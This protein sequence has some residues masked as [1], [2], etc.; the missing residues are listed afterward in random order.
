MN[1]DMNEPT[2]SASYASND[3]ITASSEDRFNRSRFATSLATTIARRH[4]SSCL[5]V[6][7]YAKWGE[8]KTSLLNLIAEALAGET[9]IVIV[10]FDPW[11]IRSEIEL[12]PALFKELAEAVKRK[13][14]T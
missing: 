7:L 12:I 13:I 10:R 1:P 3:P 9:K 6:G 4:D 11:L 5:V 2:H 14:P 8:G